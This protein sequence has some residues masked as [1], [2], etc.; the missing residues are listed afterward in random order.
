MPVTSNAEVVECQIA[1]QA[2]CI[3]RL[4]AKEEAAVSHSYGRVQLGIRP[5][6]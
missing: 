3:P 6:G 5:G 1:N 2:L 4:R